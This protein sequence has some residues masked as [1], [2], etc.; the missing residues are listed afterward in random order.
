MLKRPLCLLCLLVLAGVWLAQTMEFPG[1]QDVPISSSVQE[2]LTSHPQ[3]QIL[4]TT[5]QRHQGE[6]SQSVTLEHVSLITQSEKIPIYNVKLYLDSPS[7]PAIGSRILAEAQLEQAEEPGNP[8]E[9]DPRPYYAMDDIYYLGWKGKILKTS[10][11]YSVWQEGMCR[12]RETL[13]RNFET[14]AHDQGSVLSA[15][16][17]GEKSAL[18]PET[19]AYYQMAGII[20]ILAISGLHISMIGMGLYRLCQKAGAGLWISGFLSL[21]LMIQYGTFTGSGTATMR[22]VVMFLLS[23]GALLTGRCYDGFTALA[24]SALLLVA[25][26]PACIY[27]S[28]FLLS[29]GAVAGIY[30]F[31]PLL[32]KKW[33]TGFC[34]QLFTIP[35]LLWFY[36][37]LSLYGILL[38]LLLLP[39]VS[40]VLVSGIAGGLAGL[41]SMA[42]GT[43]LLLPARGLLLLY[44]WAARLGCSLPFCTWTAGQPSWLQILFYYSL[45][46]LAAQIW[47]I[48]KD[49]EKHLPLSPCRLKFFAILLWLLGTFCLGIHPQ[50]GL[51]IT[52][53]DVGQGDAIVL[54]MPDG[55]CYLTDGGSE[56]KNCGAYQILPYLKS[57]GISRVEG[58]F[59]SH[60]DE[61][62]ISG[63]REI[64]QAQIDKTTSV[65]V[66]GLF[67]P[68]WNVHPQAY[69]ALEKLADL[70]D[71]PVTYLKEGDSLKRQDVQ[72]QVLAP[73]REDQTGE[74]TNASSMV[75]KLSYGNITGLLTGDIGVEQERKLLEET[76]KIQ[77]LKAAHHGSK[78]SSSLEFLQ[79]ASPDISFISC[80]KD[81]R[82]GHPHEETLERLNAVKSRI[83]TTAQRGALTLQTD[84]RNIKIITFK[85]E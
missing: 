15:M 55:A 83:Y 38:N 57:Q 72:I 31:Q 41:F 28:G 60:T 81:N 76:G 23:V 12:L 7:L 22:A 68:Q 18:E 33:T 59:V 34:A 54:R 2:Y 25:E 63:I 46:F 43:V 52:C 79:Q 9:F 8:G 70:A 47:R 82:Y 66:K 36:G 17:L 32:D 75:L 39:T 20:H 6:T 4:G 42:V 11:S 74:D 58:I 50:E 14:M 62:H 71:I 78:N 13:T 49:K 21:L 26:H 77:F 85:R 10:S 61:D 69:E 51:S 80:G 37:E 3:C 29:F 16:L 84:G 40:I 73:F 24:L 67:L 1:F 56:S 65:R 44:E 30:Y 45:L 53:L 35:V 19:K 27:N 48:S 64:L 5:V